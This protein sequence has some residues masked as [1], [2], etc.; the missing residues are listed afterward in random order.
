MKLKNLYKLIRNSKIKSFDKEDAIIAVNSKEKN[1]FFIR[2]GI[3]RSYIINEKGEEVTF[4]VYA[5]TNIFTNVHSI[6]FNEPSKFTYQA[7][8]ATKVYIIDYDLFL[9]ITSKNPNLLELNRT[10]FG[11]R[12]I[13]RAFQRSESFVFLSPEERYKKFVKDNP[14]IVNRI[15]DMYIANIIGITPVSLSRIRSR[16]VSKKN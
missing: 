2:K 1:I 3:V 7:I 5:E 11:K 12:I 6:L 8:E 16:I 10:Y 4:Q 13:K 15:P 9:E 14:N